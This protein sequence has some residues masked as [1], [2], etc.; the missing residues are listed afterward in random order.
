MSVK[1][2]LERSRNPRTGSIGYAARAIW[3]ATSEEDLIG[4]LADETS[5]GPGDIAAVVH[6]L[7]KV[8]A[9]ELKA[10]RAVHL[11]GIGW[12]FV[13]IQS[14]LAASPDE[15]IP[16]LNLEGVRVRF[17]PDPGLRV[18]CKA[19]S[20]IMEG[21]RPEAETPPEPEVA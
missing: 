2:Q 8:L 21:P 14:K 19:M 17:I 12:F 9:A 16:A 6:R 7:G 3:T 10:G 11:E 18:L 1:Y 13:A 15:F 5:V 20:L 4:R